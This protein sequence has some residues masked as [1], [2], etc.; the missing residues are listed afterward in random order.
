MLVVQRKDSHNEEPPK[1]APMASS[2][3]WWCIL[4]RILC[5]PL[6]SQRLSLFVLALFFK[7]VSAKSQAMIAVFAFAFSTFLPLPHFL[8]LLV[9]TILL[10]IVIL[11]VSALAII[12][13]VSFKTGP[14]LIA[15]E[16][17]DGS[18]ID[19]VLLTVIGEPSTVEYCS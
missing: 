18:L 15:D 4:T 13:L 19:A 9:I 1:E 6:E 12:F 3:D 2:I 10:F 17:D 8:L 16:L 5:P 14:L 7:L 11:I